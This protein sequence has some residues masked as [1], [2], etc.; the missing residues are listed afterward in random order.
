MPRITVRVKKADVLWQE[1]NSHDYVDVMVD[2]DFISMGVYTETVQLK[3]G[4]IVGVIP[5]P[6]QP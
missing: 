2:A 5:T 6:V 4:I 3:K 1:D